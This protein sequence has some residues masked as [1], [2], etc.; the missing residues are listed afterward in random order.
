MPNKINNTDITP[1]STGLDMLVCEM[2]LILIELKDSDNR[3]PVGGLR[4]YSISR[5]AWLRQPRRE[6]EYAPQG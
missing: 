4:R 6:I 3:L 1:A 2:E 5:C